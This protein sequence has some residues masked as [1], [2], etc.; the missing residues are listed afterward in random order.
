MGP[1]VED[2][3]K[4][5]SGAD[6]PRRKPS[7]PLPSPQTGILWTRKTQVKSTERI[8]GGAGRPTG[9][10]S[11]P[12]AAPATIRGT[13]GRARG[14][15]AGRGGQRDSG[16]GHVVDSQRILETSA[17]N[18]CAATARGSRN[19]S[20]LETEINPRATPERRK[21]RETGAS[22]GYPV[23]AAGQVSA[24]Q[25]GN[26]QAGDEKT[27][28]GPCISYMRGPCHFPGYYPRPCHFSGQ[29]RSP[30]STAVRQEDYL[31]G[32]LLRRDR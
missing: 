22:R 1:G 24:S 11:P 20:L 3:S 15:A 31:P 18:P 12:P 7:S 5:S 26:R 14:K 29:H 2:A 32:G 23:P 4:L 19:T 9:R 28:Q 10:P 6:R 17:G 16:C 27:G 21:N 25:P 13:C 30:G 8:H